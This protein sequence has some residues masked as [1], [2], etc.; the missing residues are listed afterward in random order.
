MKYVD[1]SDNVYLEG[2][3]DEKELGEGDLLLVENVDDK[4]VESVRENNYQPLYFDFDSEN[5][6]ECFVHS[7]GYMVSK[8][9]DYEVKKKICSVMGEHI[10]QFK[11]RN[12][13][14]TSLANNI[15]KLRYGEVIKSVYNSDCFGLVDKFKP[16]A[17]VRNFGKYCNDPSL[18]R[19]YTRLC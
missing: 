6:L 9:I 10:E 3:I 18:L 4:L 12:Q 13:S 19:D 17:I 16:G 2:E 7:R 11:F 8:K 1:M 5:R 14:I 15:L